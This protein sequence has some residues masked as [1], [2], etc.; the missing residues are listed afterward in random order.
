MSVR[1]VWVECLIL[2]AL[3]LAVGVSPLRA[4]VAAGEITGLI[5][6]QAGA[7]VPGVTVTVTNLATNRESVAVSTADGVYTAPSLASGEYRIDVRLAGFKSIR[8]S[9]IRLA[10]GATAR[11]DFGL[12]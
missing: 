5:Q 11:I 9:G 8:R 7:A 3:H 10:T 12:V 6:D 1:P 4:Q 2:L